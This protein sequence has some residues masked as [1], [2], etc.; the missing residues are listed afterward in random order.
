MVE[1]GKALVE[2]V[3]WEAWPEK[4]GFPRKEEREECYR[5]CSAQ[6]EAR[7]RVLVGQESGE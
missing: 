5:H 7:G 6:A 2:H 1:G 4:G 3:V